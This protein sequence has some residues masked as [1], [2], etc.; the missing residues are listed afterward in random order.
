MSSLIG[1]LFVVAINHL[2]SQECWASTRLLP[3]SGESAKL[4]APPFQVALTIRSDGLFKNGDS[5]LQT[6]TVT[7][8]LPDDTATR[9]IIGDLPG[10]FSTVR[11]SG[12]A[13]FAEALA[14]IFRNL[15]WD[16]ES[17][18]AK[19]VGDIAAVRGVQIAQEVFS[20]QKSAVINFTQNIKEYLT[21]E[22][23]SIVTEREIL[24]FSRQTKFLRD[25][26]ARLEKRIAKL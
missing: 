11:I 5:D 12:S 4:V 18:M 10:V 25:D 20:W 3:F 19:V 2:I 7:I 14:F 1:N 21:E 8:T 22:S 6:P 16:V 9:I 26:L 15:R 13:D 17:D 23:G 24:E